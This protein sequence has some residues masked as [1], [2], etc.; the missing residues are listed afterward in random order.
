MI[1]VG[2][3]GGWSDNFSPW[4]GFVGPILEVWEVGPTECFHPPKN[5]Y[6][7]QNGGFWWGFD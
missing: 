7:L 4:V 1:F 5:T 3:V 6:P 2:W